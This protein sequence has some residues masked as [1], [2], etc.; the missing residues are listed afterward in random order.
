MPTPKL[1]PREILEEEPLFW[2]DMPHASDCAIWAQEHC[3]CVIGGAH[4]KAIDR[5]MK[6]RGI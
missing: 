5:C 1:T 2:D 3:D 4:D 6:E